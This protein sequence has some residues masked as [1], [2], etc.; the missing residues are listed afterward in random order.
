MQPRAKFKVHRCARINRVRVNCE[1]SRRV[2]C[3]EDKDKEASQRNKITMMVR[4]LS[5]LNK[6]TQTRER[7]WE[8]LHIACGIIIFESGSCCAY[9]GGVEEAVL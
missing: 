4:L 9:C 1:Q 5:S 2:E 3:G 6:H 7:K 8:G